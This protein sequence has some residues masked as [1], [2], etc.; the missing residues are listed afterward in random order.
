MFGVFELVLKG[1]SPKKKENNREN[2][3]GNIIHSYGVLFG[4]QQT[5]LS[6]NIT[7]ILS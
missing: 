5:S 6:M 7:F 4:P 3:H 1:N 2:M